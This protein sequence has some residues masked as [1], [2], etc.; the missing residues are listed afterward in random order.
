MSYN[1]NKKIDPNYIS[2]WRRTLRLIKTVVFFPAAVSKKISR[3]NKNLAIM[4]T[5]FKMRD[6]EKR[7]TDGIR[8]RSV[9]IVNYGI[10]IPLLVGIMTSCYFI[11]SDY[12]DIKSN[13][14]KITYAP[15]IKRM[16]S[17]PR[18]A[19]KIIKEDF[20]NRTRV[21]PIGK[22]HVFPFLFGYI[23]SYLGAI[24]LSNHVGFKQEKLISKSLMA[25]KYIDENLLPWEVCYTPKAVMFI[26]YQCDAD[27]FVTNG[28]FWDDINFKPDR[29]FQQAPGNSKIILIKQ[30]YEL[31]ALIDF[32]KELPQKV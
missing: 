19:G 16:I 14:K 22:I 11:Y 12:D 7:A 20:N 15:P 2:P 28:K 4:T 10:R 6:D 30:A 23:I 25:N 17:N 27:R 9:A 5:I 29:E 1:N 21:S 32:D 18:Y 3:M 26:T 8:Y 13:V 24:V 31:P